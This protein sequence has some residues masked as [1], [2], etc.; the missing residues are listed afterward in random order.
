MNILSPS[1]LAADFWELGDQIEQVRRG[2]AQYLHI[3]VM[4]GVFVPSISFGMPILASIRKRTDLFLDVHLM[5]SE[6]G[7]YIQE[8]A[9]CGADLITVHLEAA[10]SA[11]DL[12]AQIR[13]CGVRS[14]ISIKPSTPIDTLLP[15]LGKADQILVMT[16]EPGFGGQAILPECL[17]KVQYL[18][19]ILDQSGYATDIEVDGGITKENVRYVLAAGANVIVAGSSIF[20]GDTYQN[21]RDFMTLLTS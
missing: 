15:L 16:V 14:G 18:R 11:I 12:L 1:I 21:V 4:D 20:H 10:P 19:Q 13:A 8:F 3:D 2:G 6:P 9:A 5:M 7:K 17:E